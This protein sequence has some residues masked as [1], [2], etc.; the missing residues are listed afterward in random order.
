[1]SETNDNKEPSRSGEWRWNKLAAAGA[2]TAVAGAGIM[3]FAL[4]PAQ[5]NAKPPATPKKVYVCKYVGTPGA[6]ETLQSGQ[7]PIDVAVNAIKEN[8]IV[9]GSFFNDKQ[10][11]SYV[12]AFDTG[13]PKPPRSACPQGNSTSS[14]P[15]SSTP[16]S[17]PPSSS[18]TAEISGE[19][20][21]SPVVTTST[22]TAAIEPTSTSQGPV[23]SG[24]AAGLHT[25][26]S[27]DTAVL[28]GALM[29]LGLAGF[30]TAVRPWKRG[31][32]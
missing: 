24:V 19:V 13:Q 10:G 25:P 26:V 11:R 15:P 2:V 3:L 18:S 9:V 23:P 20:S 1:M 27:G 30:A 29:A 21:S 17:T 16:V 8:P 6:N 28:G 5:G 22:V 32:H 12:L 14:P 4:N 31:A 7:N